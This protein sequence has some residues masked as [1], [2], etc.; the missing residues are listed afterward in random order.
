MVEF[1]S[2]VAPRRELFPQAAEG[3]SMP[4]TAG[5]CDGSRG[6][7]VRAEAGRRGSPEQPEQQPKLAVGQTDQV[8]RA[9]SPVF[10]YTHVRTFAR[11]A[12]A[13]G[14]AMCLLAC[15]VATW[16]LSSWQGCLYSAQTGD[17]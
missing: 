14:R 9:G 11:G 15:R 17:W 6:A 3:I 16:L 1:A 2:C 10:A 7:G 12:D 8:L 5:G 13:P 4:D